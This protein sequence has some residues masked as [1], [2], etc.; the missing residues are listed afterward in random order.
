LPPARPSNNGRDDGAV[1][2]RVYGPVLRDNHARASLESTLDDV[3]RHSRLLG[4][5]AGASR[6]PAVKTAPITLATMKTPQEITTNAS[7]TCI[8][9]GTTSSGFGLPSS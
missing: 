5:R 8:H 2:V 1:A 3:A 9:S 6:P 7:R 4:R